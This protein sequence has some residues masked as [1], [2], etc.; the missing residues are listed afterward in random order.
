MTDFDA[1]LA[2]RERVKR[3]GTQAQ[4]YEPQLTTCLIHAREPLNT[5]LVRYLWPELEAVK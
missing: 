4:W 5:D 1:Y 3:C 2:D